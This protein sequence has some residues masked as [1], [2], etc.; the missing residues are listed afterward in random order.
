MIG[1]IWVEIL[2]TWVPQLLQT[3]F[4]LQA[5]LAAYTLGVPAGCSEP[6]WT[7]EICGFSV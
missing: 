7:W 1:L 3:R 5:S 4:D 6:C 2:G